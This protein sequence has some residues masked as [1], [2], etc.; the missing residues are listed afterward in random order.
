VVFLDISVSL[1]GYVAGPNASLQ[2]PLGENGMLLHEWIFGLA[3]WR[4]RHGLEGGE[5]NADDDVIRESLSLAPGAIVMGRGMFSGGSGPWADD[6]NAN[7]WWGDHPPFDAPVFVVTHHERAPLTLGDATFTFVDGAERAFA[8]ALDTAGDR[9]VLI[10]GGA[11]VAQQALAA[12][13][14]DRLRLHVVPVLL[15]G[16]VP[17]FADGVQRTLELERVRSSPAVTH[18]DYRVS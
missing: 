3:S 18:L 11:A 14:L 15:G 16:G 2:D 4:E 5:R 7:G 10:A 17:L 8:Q 13:L 9:P 6:P 12:G 1:D